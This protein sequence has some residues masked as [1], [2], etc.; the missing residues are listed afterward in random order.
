[1]QSKIKRNIETTCNPNFNI[2]S[3]SS[4][5]S[6]FSVIKLA[7]IPFQN[8]NRDERSRMRLMLKTQIQNRINAVN[9]LSQL[10]D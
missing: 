5:K 9:N 2:H 4:S 3:K 1:M 8:L 6:E 10:L 7:N